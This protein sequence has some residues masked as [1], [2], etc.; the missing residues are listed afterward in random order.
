MSTDELRN[1]LIAD[2]WRTEKYGYEWRHTGVDWWAWRQFDGFPDCTSNEKPP[3]VAIIP[4]THTS[5]DHTFRTVQLTVTGE[6]GGNQWIEFSGVQHS[7]GRGAGRTT[8]SDKH[9][10]CGVEC[11]GSE[12]GKQMSVNTET[13]SEYYALA[14][15]AADR[16]NVSEALR[17]SE[18]ATELLLRPSVE[19]EAKEKIDEPAIRAA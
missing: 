14:A 17:Y 6:V 3:H 5:Q 15:Q 19:S 2:G 12:R 8:A 4:W 7:N 10:S 9:P 16:G 18:R 11:G 13:A 1:A